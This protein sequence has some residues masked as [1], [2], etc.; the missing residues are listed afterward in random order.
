MSDYAFSRGEVTRGDNV[1]LVGK[2]KSGMSPANLPG[3]LNSV[4]NVQEKYFF[5]CQNRYPRNTNERLYW[6]CDPDDILRNYKETS[7]NEG[8]VQIQLDSVPGGYNMLYT[9]HFGDGIENISV[10]NPHPVGDDLGK[11]DE[12]SEDVTQTSYFNIIQSEYNVDPSSLNYSIPYRF[13]SIKNT[14]NLGTTLAFTEWPFRSCTTTVNKTPSAS[15][16]IGVSSAAEINFFQ[17]SSNCLQQCNVSYTEISGIGVSVNGTSIRITKTDYDLN[18]SRFDL[19]PTQ[20]GII[21]LEDLDDTSKF[22]YMIYDN[23]TP[24]GPEG[25]S[26]E[27]EYTTQLGRG[28]TSPSTDL[29]NA[30]VTIELRNYSDIGYPVFQKISSIQESV[31]DWLD[32]FILPV[33]KNANFADGGTLE[34]IH[35]LPLETV[36]PVYYDPLSN[37]NSKLLD[38]FN[39]GD[40]VSLKIVSTEQY[41]KEIFYR[42]FIYYYLFSKLLAL[43]SLYWTYDTVN[44]NQRIAKGR[45]G[46]VITV[47]TWSLPSQASQGYMYDYC[48]GGAGTPNVSYCG[49]CYGLTRLNKNECYVTSETRGRALN[50]KNGV[51]PLSTTRS[52]RAPETSSCLIS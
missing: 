5:L 10:G 15:D 21:K 50:P 4:T 24:P 45:I 48:V 17:Q 1:Y 31:T 13:D 30:R 6:S 35:M 44:S 42:D 12:N 7:A 8:A 37:P 49:R 28:G 36:T 22:T 34:S 26:I 39:P 19:F 43:N 9:N 52:G 29:S 14:N 20:S 38:I 18:K 33:T 16:P 51:E 46:G 2:V 47:F 3:F 40:G 27:G 41:L 25:I 11:I 32:I 23:I